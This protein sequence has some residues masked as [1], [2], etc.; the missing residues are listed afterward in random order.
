MASAARNAACPCGTGT[1]AARTSVSSTTSSAA[2]STPNRRVP[3]SATARCRATRSPPLAIVAEVPA[4]SRPGRRTSCCSAA[5]QH[6]DVGA[7]AAA[8]DVQLVDRQEGQLGR[9]PLEHDP[10]GRADQHVFEHD[11]VGQDDLRRVREHGVA[12]LAVAAALP[13]VQV[14]GQRAVRPVAGLE[15]VERLEL[16]VDQR[17][18]RVDDQRPHRWALVA[19]AKDLVDDR[20]QVGEALAGAGAGGHHVGPAGGCNPERP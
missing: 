2:T 18:H 19:L 6:G 3:T 8:V 20:Q 1:V 14:E 17:V 5:Q 4:T 13:G 15:L 9:H 12:P 11:V 10:L 7:L 16:R